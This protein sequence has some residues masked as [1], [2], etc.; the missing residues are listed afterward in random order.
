MV[1]ELSVHASMGNYF[2]LSELVE[3]PHVV[4][5]FM[6]NVLPTNDPS[7]SGNNVF[8]SASVMMP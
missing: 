3:Y 6:K 4:T 8:P 1:E 2:Y 5:S 7:S